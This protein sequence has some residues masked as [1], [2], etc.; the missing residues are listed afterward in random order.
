MPGD[1]VVN[2]KMGG[3]GGGGAHA[4]ACVHT[5]VSG[6]SREGRKLGKQGSKTLMG[7]AWQLADNT[8]LF[9][10]ISRVGFL[11]SL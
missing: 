4:C 8:A 2:G 5:L 6:N 11:S 3:W 7:P 1:T 9:S 10:T